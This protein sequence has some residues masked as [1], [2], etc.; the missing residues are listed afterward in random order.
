MYMIQ[1]YVPDYEYV[2]Y[3]NLNTY[4]EFNWGQLLKLTSLRKQSDTKPMEENS[5]INFMPF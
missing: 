4:S 1:G 3:Y 2:V 5:K